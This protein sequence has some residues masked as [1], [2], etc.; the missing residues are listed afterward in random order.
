MARTRS[1]TAIEVSICCSRVGSSTTGKLIGSPNWT[2]TFGKVNFFQGRLDVYNRG[3]GGLDNNG[4]GLMLAMGIPMAVYAW[5]GV[6]RWWRWLFI[7]AVPPMLH[8][9]MM[10]STFMSGL[11]S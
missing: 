3:Y 6:S 8:A 4:A 1:N 10:T 9:V 5:E 2:E 11:P 7:A